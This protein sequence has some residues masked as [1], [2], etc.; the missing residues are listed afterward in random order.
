VV[1]SGIF[2][3]NTVIIEANNLEE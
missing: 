3:M 1:L 2:G